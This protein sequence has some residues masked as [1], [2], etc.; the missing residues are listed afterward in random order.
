M[1]IYIWSKS[2]AVWS[3]FISCI[4]DWVTKVYRA[5][6]TI[7]WT[8]RGPPTLLAYSDSRCPFSSH[9]LS[10]ADTY[11]AFVRLIHQ[12]PSMLLAAGWLSVS[13][14]VG[15]KIGFS[16]SAN[17]SCSWDAYLSLEREKNSEGGVFGCPHHTERERG[18][19]YLGVSSMEISFVCSWLEHQ[20]LSWSTPSN[21]GLVP[22]NPGF[23][24]RLPTSPAATLVHLLSFPLSLS[25]SL[26]FL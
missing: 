18:E 22:S 13:V 9:S 25:L 3:L 23:F 11:M 2:N 14:N 10:L 20:C 15:R 8:R 6:I 19:T 5:A 16:S 4:L 12:V 24:P 26:Q 7:L 21:P 1:Y 17:S